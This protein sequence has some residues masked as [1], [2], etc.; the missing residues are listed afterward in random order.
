MAQ[1]IDNG[2]FWRI[3]VGKSLMSKKLINASV[4]NLWFNLSSCLLHMHADLLITVY[5]FIAT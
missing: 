1:N 3:R 4:F 5:V 2:K